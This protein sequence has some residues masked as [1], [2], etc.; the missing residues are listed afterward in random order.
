MAYNTIKVKKYL[1]IVEEYVST[2]VAITPGHMVELTSAGLV[3]KHATA[4]GNVL[5]M[6]ALEDELQGNGVD[7]AYAVSV[8]IQVWVPVRGEIVYA[9]LADGASVAVGDFLESAGSGT[10]QKHTADVESWNSD[11]YNQ[12]RTITNLSNQIVGVALT[13]LDLTGSSDA[14]AAKTGFDA[15][16]GVGSRILVRIV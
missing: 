1:D 7:T 16:A 4:G 8:P 15:V 3:Q 6:F 12:G 5:P 11:S 9:I 14:D 2:A 13:T 10:L